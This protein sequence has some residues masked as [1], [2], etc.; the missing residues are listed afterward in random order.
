MENIIENLKSDFDV[1]KNLITEKISCSSELLNERKWNKIKENY[2]SK[3]EPILKH[4][5]LKSYCIIDFIIGTKHSDY[6]FADQC[7]SM[8]SAINNEINKASVF[9]K[10]NPSYK[11]TIDNIIVNMLSSMDTDINSNNSDF[12]NWVNELFVFNKL[13][14]CTDYTLLEMERRLS[15]NKSVDYVFVHN[16]TKEEI[17]IDVVTLQNIDP[18]KHDTED[19][20]NDYVNQRI[21]EKYNTKFSA[22]TESGVFR[23]LPVI[24]Y[25]S[26]MEKF[27]IKIN[28]DTSL[29][30]L[31][32][33]RNKVNDI[34]EIGLMEINSFLTQVRKQN[35]GDI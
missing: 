7:Q 3:V 9:V 1:I 31:T 21:K 16:E 27:T 26:G 5:Q 30:A 4:Q 24:E 19:T 15:N 33:C 22:L 13:T 18:T 29:P 25:Q 14:Y 2:A 32:I 28:L 17:L 12:K 34:E 23:V 10:T 8:I 20:F 6:V 35:N 11:G